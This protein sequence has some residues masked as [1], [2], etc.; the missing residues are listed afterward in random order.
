MEFNSEEQALT[1]IKDYKKKESIKRRI[2]LDEKE[3]LAEENKYR[4]A[5]MFLERQRQ[6]RMIPND[7]CEW[8]ERI[9]SLLNKKIKKNE[10]LIEDNKIELKQWEEDYKRNTEWANKEVKM[11]RENFFKSMKE[12]RKELR[13][14][15]KKKK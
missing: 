6:K 10:K 8:E 14:N 9:E 1:F 7:C 3:K 12:L 2:K 4:N 15:L 5:L 13:A 11:R